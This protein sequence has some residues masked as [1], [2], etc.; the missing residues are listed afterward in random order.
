MVYVLQQWGR[1]PRIP[2]LTKL[3]RFTKTWHDNMVFSLGGVFSVVGTLLSILLTGNPV[4]TYP[5]FPVPYVMEALNVLGASGLLT[6]WIVERFR[7][8]NSR[9]SWRLR[10]VAEEIGSWII[11]PVI[12]FMLSGMPA[13]HA[14]TKMLFG[15][16]LSYERTPKGL[17]PKGKE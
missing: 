5:P 7:C 15:G 13:L 1:H 14:H 9:Y 16:S 4:I 3:G 17:L 11:F 2:F 6:I 10:V 12:T 8:N